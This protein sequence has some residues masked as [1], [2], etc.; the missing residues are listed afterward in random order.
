MDL[1]RIRHFVVLAETLSF[2]RAAERLHMSQPP[3]TVSIQKLESELGTKLFERNSSGVAL[4]P[5]GRALVS[6]ARKLL[7]HGAQ[8][9]EIVRSGMDGTGGTL[10]VGFVGTSTWGT[11]QKVI[12]HFRAQFPGVELVLHEATSVAILQQLE[13]HVLDVGIVRTPLVRVTSAALSMLEHHVFIAALPRGHPLARKG[14]LSLAELAGDPFI[15]YAP[16]GAGGLH[17][18]A[19]LACQRAGFVPKVV[20]QGVQVQTVLALVESG[21][22]VALVPSLMQRYVSERIVYREIADVADAMGLGLAIAFMRG[23]ESPAA[24]RFREV[25]EKVFG[26]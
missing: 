13:D 7:F 10:Q 2:R 21:L 14:S 9:G 24:A 23:E 5:S 22:G 16:S 19:M 26:S 15:M 8:L 6:E 1:R 4:T 17:S 20:Q 11:L 25:A 3:L 12:P 18:V